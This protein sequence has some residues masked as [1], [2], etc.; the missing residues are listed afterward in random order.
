MAEVIAVDDLGLAAAPFDDVSDMVP[1][2]RVV[3]SSKLSGVPAG[4]GL[5][6]R[7]IDSTGSPID[8]AGPLHDVLRVSLA[9]TPPDPMQRARVNRPLQIGVRAI[10]A[11]IPLGAGQRVSLMAGSGVGKSTLMGMITRNTSA[12]VVVACLVGERNRELGE[13]LEDDLGPEGLARAVV[14]CETS[15]RSALRRMRAAYTA[16]RIAEWFRDQGCDVLLLMDS[17]SRFCYAHRDLSLAAGALPT[18]GGYPPSMPSVL[19]GLLERAGC[20]VTGSITGIYTVLVDGDDL[21]EPVADATRS[22]LDGHVVLSR[23]LADAGH[24]PPIDVPSS[25]SRCSGAV[26]TDEEQKVA[27]RARQL[28]AA[29]ADRQDLIEIGAYKEGSNHEIDTAIALRP[30]LM[31]V[32]AQGRAETPTRDDAF[33]HLAVAVGMTPPVPSGVPAGVLGG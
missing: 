23:R 12:Q 20:G 8:G 27:R 10:D 7:V 16:T 2:D 3:V 15:E 29:Y 14:V 18:R 24:Y 1:G 28:L 26:T 31:S 30:G 9:N 5:L 21:T 13:F 19:A 32:L 11:A 17:L 22:I 6:G 25:V 4:Y 33:A